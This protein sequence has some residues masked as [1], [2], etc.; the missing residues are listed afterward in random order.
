MS[1]NK[2]IPIRCELLIDC[3]VL[4]IYRGEEY[5]GCVLL[6][7]EFAEDPVFHSDGQPGTILSFCDMAIIQECWNE[8]QDQRKNPSTRS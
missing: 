4:H 5:Q 7:P 3:N 2:Y 6:L 1:E 8:M